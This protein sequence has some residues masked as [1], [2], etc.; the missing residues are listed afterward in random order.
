[1]KPSDYDRKFDAAVAEM[2]NAGVWRWNGMPPYLRLGRKLG[3]KPRPPYYVSFGKVAV[4]SGAYFAI[5]MGV[6][7]LLIWQDP[8]KSVPAQL[9][10]ALISG[11]LFGIF[12][13]TWYRHVCRKS[14]L[15]S[16]DDL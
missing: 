15:S 4:L 9:I 16:W 14:G 10:G 5:F 11:L 2:K 12:M 8:V 13:A 6:Y 3:F 7:K 1:M